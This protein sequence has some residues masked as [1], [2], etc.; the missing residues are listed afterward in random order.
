[1]NT[2]ISNILI[3]IGFFIFILGL[4]FKFLP[5]KLPIFPGDIFYQ[6]NGFTF[7]FPFVTSVII[8]LLLTLIINLFK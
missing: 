7:Y 6:K 3:Q 5:D 2:N 4:I 1:M 8:S